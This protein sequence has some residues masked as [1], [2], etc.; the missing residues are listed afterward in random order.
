[1]IITIIIIGVIFLYNYVNFKHFVVNVLT[2]FHLEYL[3][4]NTLRLS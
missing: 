1:M 3:S 4:L 2:H